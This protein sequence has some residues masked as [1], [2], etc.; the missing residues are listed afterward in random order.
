[1]YAESKMSFTYRQSIGL[2]FIN[3]IKSTKIVVLVNGNQ[4][5]DFFLSELHP[6]QDDV[7]ITG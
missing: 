7:S 2:F 3:Q 4:K 5:K 6:L 1:M